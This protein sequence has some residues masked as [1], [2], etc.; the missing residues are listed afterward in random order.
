M[1]AARSDAINGFVHVK[2]EKVLL[3]Y[4]LQLSKNHFVDVLPPNH[5]LYLVIFMW[6]R[7]T[8]KRLSRTC[9]PAGQILGVG[10][11]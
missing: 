11:K 8:C 5:Y 1:M 4:H 2:D 6:L 10:Y 3:G 7:W 9:T